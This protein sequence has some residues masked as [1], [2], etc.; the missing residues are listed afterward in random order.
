MNVLA[1]L[2]TPCLTCG[3]K[4]EAK[5]LHISVPR[6]RRS[7]DYSNIDLFYELGRWVQIRGHEWI[8]VTVVP[9]R[10]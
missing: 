5:C 8:I 9:A 3:A 4:P 10:R 2:A 6:R 7:V 1:I